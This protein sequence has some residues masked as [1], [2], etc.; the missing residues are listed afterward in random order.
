VPQADLP[1]YLAEADIFVFASS[2]ENMPVTLVEAMAVGLPIACSNRGPMPEVLGDGG[3]YFDPEDPAG[4]V[5]A[6][7]T[8][9]DDPAL[10]A[11]CARRAHQLAQQYSWRRCAHETFGFLAE[12][13]ATA[14]RISET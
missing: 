8:L 14:H 3:V 13:A 12:M 5:G 1:G 7:Q 11:H 10:R 4:I 6:V 9:I 2:C